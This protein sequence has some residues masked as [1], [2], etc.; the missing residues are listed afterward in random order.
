MRNRKG[1]RATDDWTGGDLALYLATRLVDA[2]TDSE[3][4]RSALMCLLPGEDSFFLLAR[5]LAEVEARADISGV[6]I[7]VFVHRGDRSNLPDI[8]KLLH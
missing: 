7:P 2:D 6:R 1:F 4:F 8:L 5:F 3:A